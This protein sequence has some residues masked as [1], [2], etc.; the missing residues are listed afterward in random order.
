MLGSCMF[1]SSRFG[2]LVSMVFRFVWF[3]LN[4][5]SLICGCCFSVLCISLVFIVL[6]LM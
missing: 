4:I 2:G 5:C 1:S 6:F 3:V